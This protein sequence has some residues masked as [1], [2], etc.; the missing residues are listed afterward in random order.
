MPRVK[1]NIHAGGT[2]WVEEYSDDQI[3][4]LYARGKVI[5][6]HVTTQ[7]EADAFGHSLVDW[8]NNGLREGEKPRTLV[9]AIYVLDADPLRDA[10]LANYQT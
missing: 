2:P 1:L 9:S 3:A 8:F 7:A 4:I 5:L 6:E 10:L